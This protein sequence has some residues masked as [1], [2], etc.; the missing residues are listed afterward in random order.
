VGA[1]RSP[2]SRRRSGCAR[3]LADPCARYHRAR[4]RFAFLETLTALREAFETGVGAV[5]C[6]AIHGGVPAAAREAERL[7]FQRCEARVVLF[8]VEE[9]ISL[10]QGEHD[11]APRSEVIHD[12]RWSA[13]QMRRCAQ[14]C[15]CTRA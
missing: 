12:L 5:R 2:R 6:A 11:D 10:H 9:G 1:I 4:A 13:I 14:R 15:Q 8:T 3:E 7:R